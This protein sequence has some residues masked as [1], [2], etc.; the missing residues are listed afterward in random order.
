M[1]LAKLT[2]ETSR[3]WVALFPFEVYW[4]CDFYQ[5]GLT[6]F[7]VMFGVPHPIIP[8]LQAEVTA[9]FED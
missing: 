1:T 8:S 7:E 5:M 2:L 3:D 4:V 9:E 6:P